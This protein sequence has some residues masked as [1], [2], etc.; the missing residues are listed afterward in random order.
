MTGQSHPPQWIPL[1]LPVHFAGH[2]RKA[3]L[4]RP[5]HFTPIPA[6]WGFLSRRA[7]HHDGAS[8]EV[9]SLDSWDLSEMSNKT[10][11]TP[12]KLTFSSIRDLHSPRNRTCPGG[13]QKTSSTNYP[14]HI[15]IIIWAKNSI[16]SYIPPILVQGPICKVWGPTSSPVS[17]LYYSILLKPWLSFPLLFT[18]SN[19]SNIPED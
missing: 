19:L 14:L 17:P 9:N 1:I 7:S 12:S 2:G 13:N 6:V 16:P 8:L 18:T 4:L 10:R 15:A 3:L 11:M 5:A